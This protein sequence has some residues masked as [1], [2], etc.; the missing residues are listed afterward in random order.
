MKPGLEPPKIYLT[1]SESFRHINMS[2]QQSMCIIAAFNYT[3]LR[4]I[5]LDFFQLFTIQ[6]IFHCDKACQ[7]GI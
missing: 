5:V 1:L 6:F 3:L 4:Q 2:N 7:I